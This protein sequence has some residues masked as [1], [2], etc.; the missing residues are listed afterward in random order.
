MLLPFGAL[1][2]PCAELRD[3]GIGKLHSGVDGRHPQR[4]P[5]G[6]DT[7][8]QGRLGGV[9]FDDRAAATEVS[10]RGGFNVEP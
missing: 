10:F 4:R 9:A 8:D 2:D 1:L 6:G 3:L 5:F 7:V